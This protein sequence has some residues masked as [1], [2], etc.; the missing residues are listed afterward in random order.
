MKKKE[1]TMD[2]LDD[3]NKALIISCSNIRLKLQG[4]SVHVKLEDSIYI[5]S[6]I[7][8]LNDLFY[9]MIDT[10]FDGEDIKIQYNNTGTIFWAKN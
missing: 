6:S 2:M 1:I 9:K 8:N 5:D 7:I 4:T 3:L 10:Y